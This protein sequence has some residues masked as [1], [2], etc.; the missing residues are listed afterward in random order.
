MVNNKTK[1]FLDP[2]FHEDD[3]IKNQTAPPRKN[4]SGRGM[5][6]LAVFLLSKSPYPLYQGGKSNIPVPILKLK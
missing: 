3:R 4:S 6:C 5:L 1:F 2:R